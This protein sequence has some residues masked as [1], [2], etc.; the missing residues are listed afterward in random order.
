MTCRR[1][2][3]IIGPLVLFTIADPAYAHFL[4]RMQALRRQRRHRCFAGEACVAY[5]NRHATLHASLATGAVPRETDARRQV[6]EAVADRHVQPRGLIRARRALDDARRHDA[7]QHA[8]LGL[9]AQ[10]QHNSRRRPGG[11]F[12][13]RCLRAGHAHGQNLPELDGPVNGAPLRQQVSSP[14]PIQHQHAHVRHQRDAVVRKLLVPLVRIF[15]EPGVTSISTRD[16]CNTVAQQDK[17]T[18]SES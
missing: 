6:D 3:R 15:A 17:R 1:G 4:G 10:L 2:R 7:G 8:V 12:A 14:R 18:L 9:V 11:G 16:G 13:A 5:H